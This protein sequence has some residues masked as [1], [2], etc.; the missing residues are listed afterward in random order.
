MEKNY[1][2]I[3]KKIYDYM[4][5]QNKG[6]ENRITLEYFGR[7]Y[8]FQEVVDNIHIISKGMKELG[9][10]EGDNVCLLGL[11]T[12]EFV[13]LMY[14]FNRL[15]VTINVLNPVDSTTYD[16]VIERLNPKYIFCLDKFFMMIKGKIDKNKIVVVSVMD[17]L[18]KVVRNLNYMALLLQGKVDEDIIKYRDIFMMGR[19]SQIEVEDTLYSRD[20]KIIEIGTGGST[21]VPKQVGISNEM[22]NNVIRQHVIMNNSSSFDITFNDN[23]IFLDIIPP[24]LA[25][26][27]CDIH[28]ALSLRLKLCLQPDPNPRLF[29]KQLKKYN[30][31]HVLA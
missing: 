9:V 31:H 18:P 28:M 25:Y 7:E 16:T 17:S 20:N 10:G 12:P 29:I 27:I 3:D 8:T 1:S 13:F 2:D 30:P 19:N 5:E 15:G 26:G 11:A 24:H 14:A 23:E 4:I 21:G 6:I 22:L